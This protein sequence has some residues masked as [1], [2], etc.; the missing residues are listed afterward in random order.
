M[1]EGLTVTAANVKTE[2]NFE[3]VKQE[4]ASALGGDLT[5]HDLKLLV[6]KGTFLLAQAFLASNGDRTRMSV[7]D[8][9]GVVGGESSKDRQL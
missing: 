7:G 5:L 3:S 2:A 9:C 1:S 4:P 8:G 6:P